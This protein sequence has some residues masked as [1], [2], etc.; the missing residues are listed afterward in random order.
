M[1]GTV[2]IRDWDL[3]DPLQRLVFDTVATAHD[4]SSKPEPDV[5]RYC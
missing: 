3:V 2:T 5:D 1:C 4:E